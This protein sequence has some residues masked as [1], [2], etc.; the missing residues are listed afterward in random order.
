MKVSQFSHEIE[1][2]NLLLV[3]NSHLKHVVDETQVFLSGIR[4]YIGEDCK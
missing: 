3:R 1:T 4:V 2:F